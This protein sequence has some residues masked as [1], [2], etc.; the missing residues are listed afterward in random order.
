VG[1]KRKRQI[2]FHS[3]TRNPGLAQTRS[4]FK[5]GEINREREESCKDHREQR[6]QLQDID[7]IDPLE[8]CWVG[9]SKRNLS[10]SLSLSFSLSLSLSLSHTHTHTHTHT[11]VCTYKSLTM[12]VALTGLELTVHLKIALN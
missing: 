11:P 9:K 7:P 8:R 4:N 10:L 1:R 6:D 3:L 12:Y 5:H 2:P